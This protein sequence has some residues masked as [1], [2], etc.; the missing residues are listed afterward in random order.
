MRGGILG[1]LEKLS[2]MAK[3]AMRRCDAGIENGEI[4]GS[5]GTGL[6]L[7]AEVFVS[8]GLPLRCVELNQ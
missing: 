4:K 8:S 3:A 5:L 2:G 1:I 7:F 6:N